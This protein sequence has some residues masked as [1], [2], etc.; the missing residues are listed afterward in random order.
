MKLPKTTDE[1]PKKDLKANNTIEEKKMANGKS[2]STLEILE[3]Q[4]RGSYAKV[5]KAHIIQKKCAEILFTR[6]TLLV[7]VQIILAALTVVGLVAILVGNNLMIEIITPALALTLLCVAKNNVKEIA[8][9][10]AA[11]AHNM[12]DVRE[13]YLSLLTDINTGELTNNEIRL[14]RD[15]LQYQLSFVYRGSPR[16]LSNAYQKAKRDLDRVDDMNFLNQDT[17][18]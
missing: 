8:Q 4:I 10:H 17:E 2:S 12:W 15:A 13:C 7:W 14:K 11:S 3:D 16:V 18:K 9:K 5:I 6:N 1:T